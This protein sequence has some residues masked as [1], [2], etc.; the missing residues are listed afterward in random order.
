MNGQKTTDVPENLRRFSSWRESISLGPFFRFSPK[1]KSR[2]SGK[3]GPLWP[4]IKPALA[5]AATSL[6]TLKSERR[7]HNA[8]WRGQKDGIE[9]ILRNVGP[10]IKDQYGEAPNMMDY[11]GAGLKDI[12][13][14]LE[15]GK[16]VSAI[17]IID[18]GPRHKIISEILSLEDQYK[19]FKP[20][21]ILCDACRVFYYD[22]LGRR[23][24]GQFL[25][26][27]NK[28]LKGAQVANDVS[29]PESEF[30]TGGDKTAEELAQ[31]EVWIYRPE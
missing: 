26:G 1:S 5:L 2:F 6:Y 29:G 28:T 27:T 3:I 23:P 21:I 15:Q 24:S 4:L 8:E 18:G 30:W 25:P 12:K 17:F 9:L 10:S 13:S 31:K 11:I 20:T 19:T 22:T 7:P 16:K 14:E